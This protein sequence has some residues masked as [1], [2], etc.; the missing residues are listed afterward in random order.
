MQQH[1]WCRAT[2]PPVPGMYCPPILLMD[3]IAVG[4]HGI[5][6]TMPK[7]T[8]SVALRSGDVKVVNASASAPTGLPLP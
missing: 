1:S 2:G 7:S 8:H 5:N 6:D 3:P 4:T